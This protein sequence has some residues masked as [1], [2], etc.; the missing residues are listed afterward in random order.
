M[1]LT[2]L[3]RKMISQA[4]GDVCE[5]SVGTARN[6]EYY[7]FDFGK[8]NGQVGKDNKIKRGQVSSFTAVDKSAE[9]LEVAHEKFGA[10]FPGVLGVR[11]IIQDASLPLPGPPASANERSGSKGKKY[12]TI[13]QTMGL[14]STPD[15]VALLKNLGESVEADGKILLLEHGRGYWEWVNGMLDSLAPRHAQA[16]GCW[17]NRDIGE[18]VEKSGLEVVKIQRRNLGTTWWVELRPPK[19][20]GV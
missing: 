18:I 5:V 8:G 16:F 15:P 3:R 2:R 6:L 10:L 7:D 9:M 12:D 1:G 11:W 20:K 4:R 17:W 19:G 14:C 13:V